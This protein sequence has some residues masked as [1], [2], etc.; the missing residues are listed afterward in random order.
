[1][2]K[3]Y[4]R[5]TKALPL[6][7]LKEDMMKL[8]THVEFQALPNERKRS[9][10][11]PSIASATS[12]NSRRPSS[13]KSESP[14][15]DKDLTDQHQGAHPD[16]IQGTETDHHDS[17]VLPGVGGILGTEKNPVRKPLQIRSRVTLD[18]DDYEA[19]P[20]KLTDY[21]QPPQTLINGI[22][23][24]GL[25]RYGNP[26]L[27]GVL[28]QLWLPVKASGDE[29]DAR[30]RPKYRSRRSTGHVPVTLSNM[31]KR[32]ESARKAVSGRARTIHRPRR[33]TAVYNTS[34]ASGGNSA[35]SGQQPPVPSAVPST[36]ANI[37]MPAVQ[38]IT[39]PAKTNANPRIIIQVYKD[40]DNENIDA[41]SYNSRP[42]EAIEEEGE[43]IENDNE[44]D[45]EPDAPEVHK[46][47]YHHP[48]RRVSSSSIPSNHQL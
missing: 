37:D 1:M 13:I 21:R 24:T 41:A 8:P 42:E 17:S 20:D 12:I 16:A 30:P 29:N 14:I 27:I 47:Y 11:P 4:Y 7:L 26:V 35:I 10:R 15:Q 9:A 3:A 36:N 19:V 46:T 39:I 44:S 5:S 23:D 32:A 33:K 6:Q 38:Q 28:P 31:V 40:G 48:E 34:V 18:F 45:S 22:L 43:D 2:D 25:R